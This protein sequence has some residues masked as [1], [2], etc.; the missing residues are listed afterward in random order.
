MKV[1]VWYTLSYGGSKLSLNQAVKVAFVDTWTSSQF[2]ACFVVY[3][4]FGRMI[5]VRVDSRV[6]CE[7]GKRPYNLTVKN[8][9][10]NSDLTFKKVGNSDLTLLWPESSWC[11]AAKVT[12]L[13][14][15]ASCTLVLA[16]GR[17]LR[18][19]IL[20]LN[21]LELPSVCVGISSFILNVDIRTCYCSNLSFN[22]YLEA[23]LVAVQSVTDQ[24]IYR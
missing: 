15:N 19:Y 23:L 24:V 9:S 7:L 2:M 13:L 14:L 17:Q 4:K 3:R 12:V 1:F 16:W 5:E 10:A 20:V 21:E 8:G 22:N 11:I 6:K 18:S